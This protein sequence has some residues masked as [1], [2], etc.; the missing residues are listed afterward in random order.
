MD[1][2]GEIIKCSN[3]VNKEIFDAARCHLGALAIILDITWQCEKAYKLCSTRKAGKLDEVN[4]CYSYLITIGGPASWDRPLLIQ[5]YYR[6]KPKL[7]KLYL[8]WIAL[9][10]LNCSS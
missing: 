3:N 8:Y 4:Q 5:C 6:R 2:Q 9:S 10:V 7:N 1:A